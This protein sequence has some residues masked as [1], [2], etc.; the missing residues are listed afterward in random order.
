MASR[1]EAV[2]SRYANVIASCVWDKGESRKGAAGSG[3]DVSRLR[4]YWSS[5][6]ERCVVAE[7][8][9]ERYEAA[10]KA[11]RAASGYWDACERAKRSVFGEYLKSEFL[12]AG[13]SNRR[14]AALFPSHTG[15]MTGCVSNWL[16]GYNCPTDSQYEVIREHLNMTADG[17]YLRREYEDLRRPFLLTTNHQWSDIWRFAIPRS[18]AH[19][20][21]KPIALIGQIVEVSSRTGDTVLDPFV[22]SG[23]TLVAAKNLGRK[24]VG[25]EIEERYCEIAAQRLSQGVLDFGGAT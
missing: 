10:D 7:K 18:R 6:G 14:V 13:V 12:R 23:T 5:N 25:I 15:N 2:I 16:L 24:A 17:D 19:P 21:E 11:A 4:T 3:V 9:P 20:T 1:V 8:R 22:G